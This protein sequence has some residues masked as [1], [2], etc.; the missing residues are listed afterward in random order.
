V[1]AITRHAAGPTLQCRE[2]IRNAPT[3]VL[4]EAVELV[5][6]IDLRSPP[7]FWVTVGLARGDGATARECEQLQ[8]T[9]RSG[10]VHGRTG[11]F[12]V[13]FAVTDTRTGK[14]LPSWDTVIVLKIAWDCS[15]VPAKSPALSYRTCRATTALLSNVQTRRERKTLVSGHEHV[16]AD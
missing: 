1:R 13:F 12:I 6:Y 7:T 3:V 16:R 5:V 8:S 2:V 11:A 15:G 4:I 10:R 9:L 14:P